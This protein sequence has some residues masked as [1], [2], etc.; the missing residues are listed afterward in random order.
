MQKAIDHSTDRAILPASRLFRIFHRN[1]IDGFPFEGLLFRWIKENLAEIRLKFIR[2]S[3]FQ[4]PETFKRPTTGRSVLVNSAPF[5]DRA[6]NAP[7]PLGL[8]E[9]IAIDARE[10]AALS[11]TVT[12][13]HQL[14]F[15]SAL[16]FP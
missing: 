15:E 7:F 3:L 16:R 6:V 9:S 14:T 8:F 4:E 5:T 10:F 1:Q 2:H 12:G 13:A 11:T